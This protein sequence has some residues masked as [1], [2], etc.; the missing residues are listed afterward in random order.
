VTVRALCILTFVLAHARGGW[1]GPTSNKPAP[2]TAKAA[3]KPVP[4][5]DRVAG[6]RRRIVGIL[7]VRVEGVPKEIAAQFQSELERQLDS[8][9]YWLA[10]TSSVLQM[11]ANSTRWTEGC[12]V[13]S[14]LAEV[15]TQTGAEIVLLA[16]I[17]GADN[18][19]GY[20]VT[21]VRTDNGRWLSQEAERCDVC[22][23]NEVLTSATLAAVNLLTAVPDV[24]PDEA[25]ITSATIA[26]IASTH[27]KALNTT[28]RR[29]RRI[30]IGTVLT[31]LLVAGVGSALFFIDDRPPY[32][33]ATAAAG[34][35][36]LV[37]GMFSLNF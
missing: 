24:L 36:L 5:M 19:F 34:G 35:G 2:P 11:M 20:V 12:V 23:V 33:I 27:A 18:T 37:A 31:G 21:L 17:T 13:G 16:T 8:R 1:A 28:K 29:H 9:E 10:T 25:A 15:R 30:A 6:D 32:A 4:K 14:C 22:T 26:R 7:D 3:D